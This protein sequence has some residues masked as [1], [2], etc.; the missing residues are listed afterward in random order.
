M[1]GQSLGHYRIVEKIG[2]GGM[3]TVYRAEDTRLGRTVAL[4]ILSAERVADPHRLARF[5]QEARLASSLNHPNIAT[6]HDVGQADGQ[7]Y[8]AM[9]FVEGESL[10]RRV[11]EQPLKLPELLDLALQIADALT[12]AHAHGIVHR[13]I[14]GD[15]ITSW[16]R[17][18]AVSRCSTS[19]WPSICP[20]L[21]T[22]P[23]ASP[24]GPKPASSW[25][26]S[27]TCLRNKPSA[28]ASTR[29]PTCSAS[30]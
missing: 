26:P 12:D 22:P 30:A 18:R 7:H 16:S 14:K 27:A 8:I 1:T 4:K 15:N 19:A 5:L 24:P 2:E 3:G 23:P 17:R 6:I 25:E 11:A 21:A 20:K 13:D 10:R 29:L 28:S 9:E